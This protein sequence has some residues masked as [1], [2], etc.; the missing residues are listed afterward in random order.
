MVVACPAGTDQASKSFPLDWAV[1]QQLPAMD[2]LNNTLLHSGVWEDGMFEAFPIAKSFL[3]FLF[4]AHFFISDMVQQ[5]TE[6]FHLYKKMPSY[7][8]NLHFSLA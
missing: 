4:H 6:T 2:W 7:Y 5:A 8:R 3:W 1:M